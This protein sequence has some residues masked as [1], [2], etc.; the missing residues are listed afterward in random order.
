M[1]FIRATTPLLM[2]IIILVFTVGA[3]MVTLG[4]YLTYSGFTANTEFSFFGQTFKSTN[5]GIAAMF[6]GAAMMVLVSQRVLKTIDKT[7]G[8]ETT[9]STTEARTS[10]RD[11]N[12]KQIESVRIVIHLPEELRNPFFRFGLLHVRDGKDEVSDSGPLINREVL[13]K[14]IDRLGTM[15][16]SVEPVMHLGFQFKCYVDHQGRGFDEVKNLLESAGFTLV[17]EGEGRPFRAWFILPGYSTYQT[18]DGFTN[19]FYYPS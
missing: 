3:L 6:L 16:T 18:I 12:E 1:K 17:S 9:V 11:V 13:F 10:E 14:E 8:A 4:G 2:T 5:V 15:E 7:V 19:N